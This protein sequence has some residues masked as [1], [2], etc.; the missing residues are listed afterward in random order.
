MVT[1]TTKK[2]GY[3]R[4]N[5]AT[6]E[7]E[8][9][10]G[11]YA[12]RLVKHTPEGDIGGEEPYPSALQRWKHTPEGDFYVGEI[13][14][15]EP[16]P[17]KLI[18]GGNE[19]QYTGGEQGETPV[20]PPVE[21]RVSP[22]V[23][24]K[25]LA[26][27]DVTWQDW[28]R[29]YYQTGQ[30]PAAPAEENLKG[31]Y[32]Q[33]VEKV[34][35]YEL[36]PEAETDKQY[37]LDIETLAP[38]VTT[39][40]M[41][42]IN[43]AREAG[44]TE[45]VLQRVFGEQLLKIDTAQA[46]Y[47]KQ[48]TQLE[49][50]L[51]DVYPEKFQPTIFDDK[52]KV[53]KWGTSYGYTMEELFPLVLEQLTASMTEDFQ[54]FV[55]DLY[56]R[57]GKADGD[58]LLR[59]LGFNEDAVLPLLSTEMQ[60]ERV[61]ETI[62]AVFPQYN[63]IDDFTE[64]VNADFKAFIEDI[65][66]G[67]TTPQKIQLLE[68]MGYGDRANEFFTM[69]AENL[70]ADLSFDNFSMT[71]GYA[72]YRQGLVDAMPRMT[73]WRTGTVDQTAEFCYKDPELLRRL[74]ITEGRNDNTE[75]LVRILYPDMPAWQMTDYFSN[76]A[77][78][79]E[80]KAAE[81]G[82]GLWGTFTAGV[83][84]LVANVG[85][86]LNWLGPDGIGDKIIK[87]GQYMQVQA[88][89]VPFE[90]AEFSWK[91]VFTGEFWSTYG[92]RT[93]PTL[94]V[95]A[96]PG[97]GA[98][99]L[100]GSVATRVGLGAVGRAI[101]TGIGG[102]IL[103]RPIESALEAG[104][105]YDQAI[106]SG[107]SPEDAE[108]A[109]AKVF[110]GNLWLAGSDA[111]QLAVSFMPTPFGKAGASLLT[112]GLIK[113]ASVGTKLVITGLSEGG[114]ELYQEMLQKQAMG[115][116]RGFGEMLKDPDMN[117][118]FALG[119]AMG[120]GMGIG[121][122]IIVSIQD[123]IQMKLNPDQKTQVATDK[124][125]FVRQG[126]S[127]QVSTQKALDNV[128]E[129]NPELEAVVQEAVRTTEKE[130]VFDQIKPKDEA[131]RIAFDNL[132]QKVLPGFEATPPVTPTAGVSEEAQVPVMITKKMEV[133]LKTKGFTQTE[134][135][136]MTPAQAWENLKA[137]PVKEE[138]A[139]IV[140]RGKEPKGIAIGNELGVTYDGIQ[141]GIGM[142]FTDPKTGSTT[143]GNTLEEV[144]ANLQ[145]MRARFTNPR[146][147]IIPTSIEEAV[148]LAREA[149][150]ERE[151]AP[152]QAK[153]PT[154]PPSNGIPIDT[155]P[156]STNPTPVESNVI[157]LRGITQG[158]TK[159]EIAGNFLK[160]IV[161]G[162]GRSIGMGQMIESDPIAN[163][164]MRERARVLVTV[165]SQ[166]NA[167]GSKW[168][169]EL[170]RVFKFDKQGRITNLAGVD[171]DI[172]GAPTIQDVAARYPNYRG[173]L[174]DEQINVVK[175]LRQAIAPYRLL[176]E[177]QGLEIPYRPDVMD[178]GFYL[179]R[180]RAALEG[181]DQPTKVGGR[182][183]G[184]RKGF[185][186]PAYFDSQAAG[187]QAGYAYADITQ[188]LT[189]YA[190]DAGTR[191]T[192]TY[193]ANYFK[194]L[195]DETGQLI[196][197]TP[198]MRMMRQ[199]PEV[200]KRMQDL[201]YNL[202]RL[203]RNI[204]ALTQRQMDV[205]ELWQNDHDFGDID[206]LLDGLETM[207][208]GRERITLP[209]LVTLFEDTKQEVRALK[210]EYKT[211]MRR[212]QVTPRDQGVIILPEL[213]G[214]T[215][216]NEIANAINLILK[217]EGETV[218]RL[219]PVLNVVNAYNNLYRGI[220]A[221]LDDSIVGIQ[222]L[223]G[224][225]GDPA[226]Y[227]A[228]FKLHLGSW[229]HDGVLG[230][231]IN[232]FD[233]SR[234][235]AG[236]LTTKEMAKYG[237]HFAG[238]EGTEFSL[239]IGTKIGKL[240]GIEQANRAFSNFGDV[241]RTLWAD[242][243]IETQIAKGR[244]LEQLRQS[245][246]LDRICNIANA[247]TGW[248]TKKAF[249]S[250]GELVMFAPRFLQA[251]LETI[252]KAAMGLRPNAAL[253]QRIARNAIIKMIAIGIILTFSANAVQGEDTDF[254]LLIQDKEG[255]WRRN[256]KFMRIKFGGHYYSVFGTWDSLLGLFVNIGTGKPL[257]A[258]RNLTSGIVSN[259]WDIVTGR[260]YNYK[261][262]TDTPAHFAQ[263]IL[264]N[265]IP[266][267][268]SQAGSGAK[269]L[270]GGVV[271]G[272][273]EDVVSGAI[274][275]GMEIFGVKS[276]PEEDWDANLKR[277]G[278]FMYD[279]DTLLSTENPRYTWKLFVNDTANKISSVPLAEVSTSSDYP[280]QVQA[281]AT[282][283]LLRDKYDGIPSWTLS[284]I[285]GE[286]F[287]E[288]YKQWRDRQKLVDAGD[289]ASFTVVGELQPDG[290]TK[291]VTYKGEE[292]VK[293]YD[294][295]F[296]DARYGNMG[297]AEFVLLKEYHTLN[298]DELKKEF[299]ERHPELKANRKYDELRAKPEENAYLALIGYAPILTKEALSAF[300]KLVGNLD[301]PETALPTLALPPETSI[302]THF[303]YEQMVSDGTYAS[304]EAKLLL[305]EDYLKAQ[306]KGNVSYCE[307]RTEAGEP[308]QIPD[309]PLDYYKLQVDNGELFD[310]LDE[311]RKNDKL[312][313]AQ[314]DE[315]RAELRATKVDGET[316]A[317]I[318]RRV[319]AISKGTRENP[320]TQDVIDAHVQYMRLLDQEG[321]GSQSAE[322]MLFRIDNDAY[323]QSRLN[324]DLW[325]SDAFTQDVDRTQEAK[326]RLQ[327]DNRDRESK[328]DAIRKDYTGMSD[329][330]I[331][332]LTVPANMNPEAWNLKTA[333][334]KRRW[335]STRDEQDYLK[336][337]PGYA[338]VKLQVEAYEFGLTD[339]NVDNFVAFRQL[340]TYGYYRDRYMA[341]NPDFFKTYTDLQK[342]RG[343]D[344]LDS[345]S[346]YIP[347]VEY[348]RLYEQWKEDIDRYNSYADPES[349][350]FIEDTTKR[351]DARQTMLF[352]EGVQ[353]YSGV[354]AKNLQATEFQ[355]VRYRM[356]GL[357][358]AVPVNQVDNYVGW[359]KLQGE[360][361][362]GNWQVNS[363]TDLWYEDDWYLIEHM[364]FYR[365]IYKGLLGNEARDFTKV[366]SRVVFKEYLEYVALPHLKAKDDYRWDH[367]DL[368]AWLVL[369]FD[370]TPIAEK[371]RRE[372]LTTYEQFIEVWTE[373]GK[374]IEE[375]LKALRGE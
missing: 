208:G 34:K 336:N 110:E 11:N 338:V 102:A 277:L 354:R 331:N 98:Y 369:K 93:L 314:K 230:A 225:Y 87:A 182:G 136:G 122:D 60:E 144:K 117:M 168:F 8:W 29:Q 304:V 342:S 202:N 71:P 269:Q 193:I 51:H 313:D 326:W 291:D 75:K 254:R 69:S 33:F 248:S 196:G 59:Q 62:Q 327:A 68:Q 74:L 237:L 198:K 114:E 99:G 323:N 282:T 153:P 242:H 90:P 228:A 143:Y 120:I 135:D 6:G 317:D 229:V 113:T 173:S 367:R 177:E 88:Q 187:I 325:G 28:W 340:P 217:K 39:E 308:L 244:S 56:G 223:L 236:R 92:L 276:F 82:Q 312:T 351:N 197:E 241:I 112:R 286:K 183:R 13:G 262:T 41:Y 116:T 145:K 97:L 344:P 227:A 316:F 166:A 374:A 16:T 375:K 46:D 17:R 47:D 20:V 270:W 48:R 195:N 335:L 63:N 339:K 170:N 96:V 233:T 315:A 265:F 264:G 231:W 61:V 147:G 211:A 256:A 257:L 130:L 107:L 109:A 139:P 134:I 346:V 21:E 52:G 126:Y 186:R 7:R 296:P 124:A 137:V 341:D 299:L 348:D 251:R 192:N 275:V 1:N 171:P 357:E 213:M 31:Y 245:G 10:E 204:G 22:L 76:E 132:R 268:I 172:P 138:V 140:H 73:S 310:R 142:Q 318:E 119:A 255:R 368:D 306:E 220:R 50:M 364:D 155:N 44:I 352:T 363:G 324:K 53:V 3:W 289:N 151:T 131:Q 311:I 347:P 105:A 185:E 201:N 319:D 267:G 307:W 287:T 104:S 273:T 260:D 35:A 72:R 36:T 165:E 234:Q 156:D 258:A 224:M 309:K 253:D 169:S 23:S 222:G 176:L 283:L 55:N 333:E 207:A 321:T 199:N 167:L 218:G 121:G 19:P 191:A 206:A 81:G 263:W 40:G 159:T 210:P 200:A 58:I 362:P 365:D 24:L 15:V 125:D 332:A 292:A 161:N 279:N 100:A 66:K 30:I 300:N 181:A 49:E 295:V 80:K 214:R 243:E 259:A 345:P 115:D 38:Y 188:V 12:P 330:E 18:I 249:G 297:Q 271:E 141:E 274:N 123:K 95:L 294:K 359:R 239:G 118:V 154:T 103:S 54:G 9:I 212:A 303:A 219:S 355:I 266:F 337:D 77:L 358:L 194:T 285:D 322:A 329:E 226:A 37:R 361:K 343:E 149:E 108:R 370:Y 238:A 252:T 57:I 298:N 91:N 45:D 350:N 184:V 101:M 232:D 14:G 111:M 5:P 42:D 203:K 128:V 178:G 133:D 360:G 26:G 84:D 302:D 189:G 288:Y 160:R 290:K 86:I 328:Y 85:G 371:K 280:V 372:S 78:A 152:A 129:A 272:D 89:P 366:P 158:L 281:V 175:G 261:A 83:G 106:K 235:S 293:A 94:M 250:L 349:L 221:T 215:Y 216:P 64:S 301:I 2:T 353:S 157:G 278:L 209:E 25:E 150:V 65:Q 179:P 148:R 32:E 205:I 334:Q 27:L 174:T 247:M 305:L 284:S 240:P 180:G 79:V 70:T 163:A 356:E 43:K 246:D 67:G 146:I 162:I 164:A 190:Y 127:E 373:R 320:V 4:I